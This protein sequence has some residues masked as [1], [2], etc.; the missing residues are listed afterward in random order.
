MDKINFNQTGGLPLS[1]DVLNNMQEAYKVF[2]Q[3]GNLFSKEATKNIIVAG[4]TIVGSTASEGF[5]L[6]DNELLPFAGGTVQEYVYI[7]NEAVR[8]SFK[9]GTEK[10][11]ETKRTVHFGTDPNGNGRK[12]GDFVALPDIKQIKQ[13][14]VKLDD[15]TQKLNVNWK[16]G[17]AFLE[18]K[19]DVLNDGMVDVSTSLHQADSKITALAESTSKKDDELGREI[20]SLADQND[21]SHDAIYDTFNQKIDRINT[22][23]TNI[24]NVLLASKTIKGEWDMFAEEEISFDTGIDGNKMVSV[25]CFYQRNIGSAVSGYISIYRYGGYFIFFGTTGFLKIHRGISAGYTNGLDNSNKYIVHII[26]K[27]N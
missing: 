25:N 15:S 7:K 16:E 8:R 9:D 1:T 26:Y 19:I 24:E 6:V 20:S 2:N 11:V 21:L 18:Q 3:F 10:E 12:W 23:V 5:V 14:L 13:E 22:E 17:F 27:A 4:C